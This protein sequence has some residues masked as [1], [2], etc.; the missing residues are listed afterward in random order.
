[1][2]S[3][4]P[5]LFSS[6]AATF[7]CLLLTAAPALS[8]EPV[9]ITLKTLTAQMKFELS[10]I[11]VSPGS[12]VNLSFENPDDMPHNVVFCAPGTDVVQ[13]VTKMLEKPEEA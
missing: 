11:V 13:L 9:Q 8:Q 10:E 12:K 2:N 7:T 5:Y 6:L 4:R 3:L 1:M